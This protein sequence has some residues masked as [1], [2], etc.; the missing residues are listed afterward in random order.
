M[1]EGEIDARVRVV[2]RDELAEVSASV[3]AMLDTIVGLL[4][5]TRRQRDALTRAA[6]RLFTDMRV[7]GAGDLRAS[8]AV[9]N[10]PIGMLGNAFNLT[11]GRFRRFLLRT[12][13]GLDQL[14]GI[15]RREAQRTQTF[16][17]FTQQR[18]YAA[19]IPELPSALGREGARV[20]GGRPRFRRA[21]GT[22]ARPVRPCGAARQRSADARHPRSR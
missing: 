16:F 12:R 6:D 9:S 15:A 21:S 19:P 18:P 7:A 4:E 3:N 17:A 5:E 14:D 20:A 11:V 1:E 8:A 10:D 22:R 2:G 13:T